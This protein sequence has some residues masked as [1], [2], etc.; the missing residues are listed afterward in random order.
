[1]VAADGSAPVGTVTVTDGSK[2]IATATLSA[3][4]KGKVDIALPA[5]KRGVH[6]IRTSFTGTGDYQNS[7]SRIP[8]PVLI[9]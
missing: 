7:R 2:V 1:M 3:A 8:A 6:L 4:D 5:L 9:Y